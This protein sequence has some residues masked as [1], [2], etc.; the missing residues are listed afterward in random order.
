MSDITGGILGGLVFLV[1]MGF[2]YVAS[3]DRK[4]AFHEGYTRAIDSL[5]IANPDTITAMQNKGDTNH[6][7]LKR[8]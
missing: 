4:D 6:L 1:L 2:L 7:I 3:E 5:R 8:R